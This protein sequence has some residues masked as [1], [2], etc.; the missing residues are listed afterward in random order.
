MRSSPRFY[1]LCRGHR[2]SIG[3]GLGLALCLPIIS[4]AQIFLSPGDS[5]KIYVPV[6]NYAVAR[7]NLTNVRLSTAGPSFFNV[8]TASVLE[9]PSISPGA[10]QAFV[11]DYWISGTASTGS[12]FFSGTIQ[13]ESQ[14]L[15]TVPAAQSFTVSFPFVIQLT[16]PATPGV[17]DSHDDP[18]A[19]PVGSTSTVIIESSD[20]ISGICSLNLSNGSFSSTI[21][22]S[23]AVGEAV[24]GPFEN[25]A[26]GTYTATAT[27]CVGLS[28]SWTFYYS[29]VDSTQNVVICGKYGS[30]DRCG[31][32]GSFPND[33]DD[34]RVAAGNLA[35]TSE[36]EGSPISCEQLHLYVNGASAGFGGGNCRWIYHSGRAR[37]QNF[38]VV[39]DSDTATN[40]N[41]VIGWE[42]TG[43]NPDHFFV[44][45]STKFTVGEGFSL[46]AGGIISGTIT[47]KEIAPT[48]SAST[49]SVTVDTPFN[50]VQ[51]ALSAL[52]AAASNLAPRQL[53]KVSSVCPSV[54]KSEIGFLRRSTIT[55]NYVDPGGAPAVDTTTLKIYGWTGSSW[56]LS[57]I[58][59]LGASKSTS[60]DVI[61]ASATISRSGI[62]AVLF[63]A[64]DSSAPT[65]TLSLAGS[66]HAFAGTVF[67][68]TDA[69]VF[70]TSTDP[71]VNGFASGLATTYFRVDASSIGAYSIWGPPLQFPPGTHVIQ[72]YATDWAGNVEP[73]QTTTFTMTYGGLT[74]LTSDARVLGWLSIGGSTNGPR[75]EVQPSPFNDYSVLVSSVDGT[76]LFA[77]DNN[78]N[79]GAGGGI[80][81][82]WLTVYPKGTQTLEL[83]AGNSTASVSSVQIG[84][85]WN[86]TSSRQHG[87]WTEHNSSTVGNRIGFNVWTPDAGLAFASMT[88][89]QLEGMTALS[90][91][92]V[93]VRP[94]GTPTAELEISNGAST[95]G[96]A[97]HRA[98]AWVTSSRALKSNIRYLGDGDE[99]RASN[100]VLALKPVEFRYKT[101]LKD[102]RRVDDPL[103][104]L[105]RGLILEDS[106][107][108]IQ[109][110]NS[111]EILERIANVEMAIKQ[112]MKR[113]ES[114][115]RKLAELDAKR[116]DE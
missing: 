81:S 41:I 103:Q 38:T 4:G 84:L 72:Y 83:R 42:L 27:N 115:K 34:S 65:T 69:Y 57:G 35:I 44:N 22:F 107:K 82:A 33:P 89:V 9:L 99:R 15:M 23:G 113:L 47:V 12:F 70:L 97:F 18:L 96:G 54:F 111:L 67:F 60:T 50:G 75:L 79:V 90:G 29:P 112:A 37:T 87:I 5:G 56:T 55:F 26:V 62:Y 92:S 105:R 14:E 48:Y 71:P 100:D 19:N 32:G 53:L 6:G 101:V 8:S 11:V 59:Q 36:A 7:Q 24:G 21:T 88:L 106:P 98:Q 63:S 76:I 85:G 1:S 102:G 95:G 13:S 86:G 40:F 114:A 64:S 73:V 45:G 17:N 2:N 108:S 58:L 66:S 49:T 10:T 30:F 78:G 104:P 109:Y 51:A 61:I 52:C 116:G 39:N 93:H 94:I 20:S 46:P 110:R 43:F 31:A 25:I 91:A 16:S 68:S 28:S 80:G 74:R 3:L 77:T